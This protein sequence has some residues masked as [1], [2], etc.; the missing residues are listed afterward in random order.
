MPTWVFEAGVAPLA[1]AL[2][3]HHARRALGAGRAAGELLALAAYGFTV[4]AVAMAVFATHAYDSSWHA[5][6]LGVPLAIAVVWAAVITSAMAVAGRHESTRGWRAFTAAVVAIA[7]DLMIDPV[8]TRAGLWDWTPPGPW[9]G[10]PIGNFVAWGLIVGAYA[11]GAE[12]WAGTGSIAIQAVRRIA[13]AAGCIVFLVLVAAAWTSLGLERAFEGGRGW[14]VWAAVLLATVWRVGWR[15]AD[16]EAAS[17]FVASPGAEHSLPAR[18]AATPGLG[19]EASLGVVALAFAVDAVRIAEAGVTAAAAGSL[20]AIA[21]VAT[22][23]PRPSGTASS[24]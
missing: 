24:G 1:A 7:L 4:E 11:Y 19:P 12:R 13:L 9:L 20:V 18:L 5:S 22:R 17:T 21:V 2:A 16:R 14:A 10:V 8:A 23:V 15:R 6:A 3:F